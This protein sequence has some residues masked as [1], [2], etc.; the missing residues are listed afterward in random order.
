ME[1]REF[2]KLCGL[3]GLGVVS[4]QL[5]GTY[6]DAD[7]AVPPDTLWVFVNAG[8]GWDFT[9]V[10]DPHGNT[11]NN[12][13]WFLNAFAPGEIQEFAGGITTP[14]DIF[15]DLNNNQVGTGVQMANGNGI[16]HSVFF[17][18]FAQYMTVIRGID[19]ETNGHDTGQR[20]TW[21]GRLADNTPCLAALIA[22]ALGG[23]KPLAFITN[24]GYDST[25]NTPVSKTRLGDT[26]ALYPLIYPNELYPNPDDP[27]GGG[28]FH[29]DETFARIMA[30]R[31]ARLQSMINGQNLPRIKQAQNLLFT[32]REGMGDLK[33]ISDYLP[34]QLP[35]GIARQAAIILAAYKAG[36]TQTA[37]MGNGG[38]D[39][40]GDNDNGTTQSLAELF[41]GVQ[42]L[43]Q[44]A[45]LPEIDCADKLM[46]VMGSDFG[47]LSEGGYNDANGK[48]HW[49]VGGMIMI[50]QNSDLPGARVIG[51]TDE[52]LDYVSVDPNNPTQ[53]G[54]VA[55]RNAH[56]HDWMRDFA[57]VSDN[58]VVRLFRLDNEEKINFGA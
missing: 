31:Q 51:G 15:T 3:A 1:R 28:N 20:N 22:A 37:T 32:S 41:A 30:T 44:M 55:I 47:R 43:F 5:P 54:N 17:N 2:I 7:A 53:P 13:G 39:T 50:R 12:E 11:P 4:S 35:N 16:S 8:G 56:L 52:Y 25:Y 10:A 29:T 57:G 21:S 26:N 14:P 46:V 34:D 9:L 58:E 36:L 33:K 49:S 23:A 27:E 40:H 45:A 19:C 18:E 24:G 42:A 48:D 38:Y 6:L